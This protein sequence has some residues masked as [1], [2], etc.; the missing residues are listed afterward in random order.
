MNATLNVTSGELLYRLSGL[1]QVEL[2]SNGRD[3]GG[4]QKFLEVKAP[5]KKSK[6][7][8]T[9]NNIRSH[10]QAQYSAS[11][12]HSKH[13]LQ[14]LSGLKSALLMDVALDNERIQQ[15]LTKQQRQ[16]ESTAMQSILTYASVIKR[17][18]LSAKNMLEQ[19][20]RDKEAL[21]KQAK[22]CRDFLMF[23]THARLESR[24]K[25]DITC[26]AHNTAQFVRCVKAV[27]DNISDNLGM[28][29]EEHVRVLNVFKIKHAALSRQLHVSTIP[30]TV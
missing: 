2:I 10:V 22:V 25:L 16:F 27:H 12:E 30:T 24:G 28:V 4:I 21:K 13:T 20:S 11:T 19:E 6:E 14:K 26:L 3:T 15:Y 29:N 8:E 18:M 9:L 23:C 1:E 5:G 7:V 17:D